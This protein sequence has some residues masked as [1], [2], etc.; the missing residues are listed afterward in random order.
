MF[1]VPKEY[2]VRNGFMASAGSIGNNGA[3]IIPS[4]TRKDRILRVIASDHLKWEHVSISAIKGGSQ[5]LMPYWDEM[6]FIKDMFWD[7]TDTVIQYHPRKQDYVKFADC[8]HL[9]RP[10]GVELPTPPK[11]LV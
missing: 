6:C 11:A 5:I 1:H 2:R 10:V 4:P 9:W 3:F 8:L 7:D